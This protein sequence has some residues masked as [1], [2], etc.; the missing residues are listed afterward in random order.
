MFSSARSARPAHL[1]FLSMALAAVLTLS[2]CGG[3]NT[4]GTGTSTSAP[5]PGGSARLAYYLAVDKLDPALTSGGPNYNILQLIYDT[6]VHVDAGGKPAPGLATSWQFSPDLKTLTLTLREGLTFP[7][8]TPFDANVVKANLDR[9]KTLPSSTTAALLTSLQSTAVL[10]PTHVKLTL[11]KPDAL[12]VMDL[13]DR[14]GMM[15]SPKSFD[16]LVNAP[17]GLGQY[18]MDAYKPGVS[19]T[20]KKNP[21]Y[22]DAKSVLLDNVTIDFIPDATARLNAVRT[23]R[24]DAAQIDPSQI[25]DAQAGQLNTMDAPGVK[26]IALQVNPDHVPAYKNPLVRQAISLALDRAAISKTLYLDKADISGQVF[27]EGTIGHGGNVT[28][29]YD[30]EKAKQLMAQAG[31]A[32]GFPLTTT[33]APAYKS[34][35]EAMQAQLAKLNIQLKIDIPSAGYAVSDGMWVKKTLESTVTGFFTPFDL[36]TGVARVFG[37]GGTTNPGNLSSPDVD[38]AVDAARSSADPATQGS[39]LQS[40]SKELVTD[41]LGAIVVIRPLEI[42]AYGKKISGFSPCLGGFPCLANVG[43]SG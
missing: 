11:T 15:A 24:D 27:Q 21:A 10:D 6:L 1:A 5:K 12:I 31:Y 4:A 40:V 38:K 43:V 19:I 16:G 35:T 9:S 20:L 14:A 34:L 8:G 17:V 25:A 42:I 2:A 37:P 29:P 32:G 28:A 3:A 30:L 26:Y 39:Q 18:T 23:G 7:D 13:A 22:W 36:A 33:I 41:P